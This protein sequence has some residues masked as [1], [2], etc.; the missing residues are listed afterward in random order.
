MIGCKS[1]LGQPG[2]QH[3]AS[4]LPCG[5]AL[6]PVGL[7]IVALLAL[8]GCAS[9]GENADPNDPIEPTNREVYDFNDSLD[10]SVFKPVA[11]TYADV[12]APEFRKAMTNFFNN[13]NY[14]NV[15][16]N[17]LLQFKLLQFLSDSGRLVVNTTLGMGGLLDPATD[18]G[19]E[20]ND[21]DLG[22]T[23]GRWGADEGAYLVLPLVGPNSVRDAPNLVVAVLLNPLTYL[24]APITVPMAALNAVNTRAG[25]LDATEFR[26]QAALD[27]YT[28]VREAYRQRRDYLIYD[29]NPPPSEFDAFLDLD[30]FEAELEEA[31]GDSGEGEGSDSGGPTLKV[32]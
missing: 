13:V 17:D 23:F 9:T 6:G 24:A 21:E 2:A 12:T 1:L 26:D 32:F 28:F 11:Q 19:L 20:R 7:L 14:L 31:D 29:G 5:R 25:L 22:Q 3:A 30:E 10:R 4:W 18:L 16:L 8:G 27:P 15:I